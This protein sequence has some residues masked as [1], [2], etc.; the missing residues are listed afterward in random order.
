[1]ESYLVKH[2]EN[3][4]FYV[5]FNSILGIMWNLWTKV[6]RNK[7]MEHIRSWEATSC[8]ANEIPPLLWKPKFY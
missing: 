5:Y 1:M 2:R 6:I 3:F 8:S 4:T 7:Y